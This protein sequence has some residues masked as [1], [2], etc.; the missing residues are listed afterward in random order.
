MRYTL[1]FI[2]T[3]FTNLT[4]SG[5]TLKRQGNET[6]EMFV[7]QLKPDTMALAHPVIETTTWDSTA[8]AIIAFYGYDDP[9]DVNTGFNK[10]FGHL[11]LPMGKD[12]YRDIVFGPIE[13]DGGYP[14]I[15]SVFFANADKDKAK[16]LI[17]LCKYN[18]QHYDVSGAFYGT[19]IFDNP[20]GETELTYFKKLSE[21][22]GGCECYWRDG[23]TKT[24]KYKTAAAVKGGLL[25]MGYKQ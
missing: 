19:F 25:K 21:Q 16:E 11:Y 17:V 3:I 18:V 7:K 5:Q 12:Y 23:E 8:K 22:F 4:V 13:E 6:S 9:K 15:I 1:F 2:V 10:M 24:A 20:S 14:E